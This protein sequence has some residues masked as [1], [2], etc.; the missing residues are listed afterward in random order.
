[1]L[2]EIADLGFEYV[3]LSHGIRISLVPGIMKAVEE[4]IIKVASTHNFC[5]LP[6]GINH[7]APNVFQPSASDSR[8]RSMWLRHTQRTIDFSAEMG[9]DLIVMHS[10]SVKLFFDGPVRKLVDYRKDKSPEELAADQKYIALV[11]KVQQKV[12]KKVPQALARV[13]DSFNR[14]I[15][16]AH[17]R[18]MRFGIENRD[19][20]K[21]L[22][23]ERVYS[24]FLSQLPTDVCGYW[25][26][27][28]HAKRKERYGMLDHRI[29]LEQ[30]AK[31]SFGFHL[32]DV[33]EEGRDDQPIG[34]GIVDWQ[35]LSEFFEPHHIITI[36]L[37]PQVE[38]AEIV[39]SREY[40]EQLLAAR[41]G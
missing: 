20:F 9:A 28:G 31:R 32:K 7:A 37:G 21:E 12:E 36:E 35:M 18:G 13:L 5:P 8:E 34:T 10:G 40:V 38:P 29:H 30:Y 4:G 26:D 19:G 15:P 33:S 25:H 23:T 27:T 2:C 41:F 39:S 17:E 24:D 1:M 3:E 14:I 16:Y 11:E 22:P 6:N